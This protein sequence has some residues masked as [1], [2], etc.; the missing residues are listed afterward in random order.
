MDEI[1]PIA[2]ILKKLKAFQPEDY[3]SISSWQ[4]ARGK[5]APPLEL[6][7]PTGFIVKDLAVGFIY[8]TQSR[9]AFIEHYIANPLADKAARAQAMDIITQMICLDAQ[10]RGVKILVAGTQI[11][12]IETLAL[13]NGFKSVGQQNTF[14]KEI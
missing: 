2:E 3:Q 6:L 8:Y 11:K 14:V 4:A 7:P 5:N 10:M 12:N 1:N 13:K 9:L